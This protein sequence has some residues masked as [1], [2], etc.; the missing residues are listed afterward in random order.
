MDIDDLGDLN[1]DLVN[2][3]IYVGVSR[4]TFF[5]GVTATQTLPNDLNYMLPHFD[6]NGSW[7]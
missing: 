4:A 3:Y 2:K 1:S 6:L 5:L 7:V